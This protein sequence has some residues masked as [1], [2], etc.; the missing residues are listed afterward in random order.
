MTVVDSAVPN[1]VKVS[2]SFTNC[3]IVG[4]IIGFA[5]SSAIII[6]IDSLDDTIHDDDYIANQYD[7]PL[8]GKVQNLNITGSKSYKYNY[9]YYYGRSGSQSS[10]DKR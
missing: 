8:L 1:N 9:N 4:F 6:I 10:S 5:L 7:C 3:I 2:P